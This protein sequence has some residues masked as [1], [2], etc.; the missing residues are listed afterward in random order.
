MPEQRPLRTL[1]EQEFE[2]I[3]SKLLSEAPD[4][5]SEQDFTIWLAP[6]LAQAVGEAESSPAPAEG[7]AIGRFGAGVG[8]MLNP[9]AAVQGIGH[10]IAHPIDTLRNIASASGD[11]ASKAWDAA[12]E[13]RASEAVGHGLGMFPV[14]G[15]AAANVGEKMAE[16]FQGGDLAGSMGE[17]AGLLAPMGAPS[18]IRGAARVVRKAAPEGV[19][20]ATATALEDGAAARTADVMSPK[21]GP[22]KTRFANKATEVAP[23]LAKDKTLQ[24]GWSREALHGKVSAKYTE[25]VEALDAAQDARLSAR[26]FDT[27]PLISDL[28]KKRQQLTAETVEAQKTTRTA[29]TRQSPILDERGRPISVTTQKAE[30]LGKDVVPSPNGARVAE[31]D[32]AIA[33]LRE[34]GPVARYESIR[35]I[36]QAYDAPAKTK[37]NPSLTADYL[38]NQGAANGA[39]DVTGVLREHLAKF[40]PRTAAANADYSLYKSAQDVLEAAA[41]VERARPTMFRKTMN[42]V[43]GAAAGGGLGVLVAEVSESLASAG[44]TTKLKTAQQMSKLAAAIRRGDGGYAATL[45]NQLKRMGAQAAALVGTATSPSGSQ[46]QTTAPA[47]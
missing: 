30:P 23:Q 42:R 33:E 29:S 27:R 8:R 31:I 25:A 22:N 28:M 40:D 44:W 11:Q 3:K 14:I 19:V 46:T 1:S 45:S 21:V 17:A 38:K 34:L 43:A 2:G 9:V 32:K 41:E 10:A 36:R 47:R 37:Y 24:G 18:A 5:L 39:A 12:K 6:R 7:S 13:G 15:P 26:T 20:A 16:G 4:G 35:R